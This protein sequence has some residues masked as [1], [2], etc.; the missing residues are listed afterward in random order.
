M[1]NK[2]WLLLG[3]GTIIG[4]GLLLFAMQH[5]GFLTIAQAPSSYTN[6]EVYE[7]TDYKG[8]KRELTVHRDARE[9]G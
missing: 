2:D 5:Y 3:V 9:T 7:W 6:E 8:R 1:D 4:A